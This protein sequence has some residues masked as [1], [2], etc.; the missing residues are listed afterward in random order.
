MGPVNAKAQQST[1]AQK[2]EEEHDCSSE[3]DDYR[4]SIQECDRHRLREPRQRA[5]YRRH[6][7]HFRCRWLRRRLDLGLLS[8]KTY[9][10][11]GKKTAQAAEG[12][13]SPH[14]VRQVFDR[15]FHA[16]GG[17]MRRIL[18]GGSA[19]FFYML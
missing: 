17:Q 9:G 10:Y 3:R 5:E 19:Q 16:R 4:R 11:E 12:E 18:T 2:H 8:P 14:Q 1:K 15:Q 6:R 7:Q 13:G